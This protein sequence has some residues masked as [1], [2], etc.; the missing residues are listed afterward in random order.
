MGGMGMMPYGGMMGG[1]PMMG[2]GMPMMGASPDIVSLGRMLQSQGLRV[3]ENPAFG[4]VAPVHKGRG[5]YE[6][7]AID[8]NVGVGNKEAYDPVHGA[9]FDML[10]NQLRTAGYHV[11]WRAPGHYDHMHIETK[12][13]QAARGGIF[14][15]PKS[16]YPMELHG[17]E[18][19]A[20]L[21]PNSLLMSLAKMPANQLLDSNM[22][23]IKGSPTSQVRDLQKTVS[24]IVAK[25]T[26]QALDSIN[27]NNK[28][29]QTISMEI[30]NS[31]RTMMDANRYTMSELTYKLSEMIDALKQSNDT[32]KKILKKASA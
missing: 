23:G 17:T 20:P 11:V 21:T 24:A 13:M 31:M 8:V 4:G 7:R 6:G 10:A 15:G 12:R 1:M 3:S 28:P 18:M 19:V 14:S 25:E 22:T 16:G 9:R 27:E 32:T 2:G 5:H 29:I 30:T 26:T